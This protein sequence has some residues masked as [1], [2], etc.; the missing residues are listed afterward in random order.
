MV[1]LGA[2]AQRFS[3]PRSGSR[4]LRIP[5]RHRIH[6]PPRPHHH[7]SRVQPPGVEDRVYQRIPE[8][9]SPELEAAFLLFTRKNTNGNMHSKNKKSKGLACIPS[10]IFCAPRSFSWQPQVASVT[11]RCPAPL[12]RVRRAQAVRNHPPFV[13]TEKGTQEGGKPK[14]QAEASPQAV[15]TSIHAKERKAQRVSRQE[16]SPGRSPRPPGGWDPWIR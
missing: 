16:Y 14:G 6:T 9:V 4:H 8:W 11:S 7:S 3:S 2:R 10:N 1:D 12:R 15:C 5:T 13:D